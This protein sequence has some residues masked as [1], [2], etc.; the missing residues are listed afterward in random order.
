MLLGLFHA[1]RRGEFAATGPALADLLGRPATPLR[2]V[3]EQSAAEP[4]ARR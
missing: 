3:L 2:V 4:V 1:S